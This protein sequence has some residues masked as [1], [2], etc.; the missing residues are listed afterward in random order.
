MRWKLTCPAW[1]CSWGAGGATS[2]A[3]TAFV[4]TAHSELGL[5]TC[6]HLTCTNMPVSMIDSALKV[7][8]AAVPYHWWCEDRRR[9]R[10]L[11]PRHRTRR[12]LTI[13]AA[14][15][16]LPC[17]VILLAAQ[18]SGPRPREASTTPLTSF[19]T[20][21]PSTAT[22]SALG[23][24]YAAAAVEGGADACCWCRLLDS[25]KDIHR[26]KAPRRR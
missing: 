4:K 1:S 10:Q 2:E 22:T 8:P 19:A 7:R 18:R 17:V 24:V 20:S 3:T 23:C 9:R 13:P 21:E 12:R 15:T 11:T 26:A 14:A 5:E 6:M 16:S 25:P